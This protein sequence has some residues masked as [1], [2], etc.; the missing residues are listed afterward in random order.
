M[1]SAFATAA[2]LA[3]LFVVFT[4]AGSMVY[5]VSSADAQAIA[6]QNGRCGHLPAAA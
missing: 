3:L 1:R 4:R 6:V 5:Y 2:L